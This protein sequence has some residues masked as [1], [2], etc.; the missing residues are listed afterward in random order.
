MIPSTPY[1]AKGLL[2]AAIRDPD[3][4]LFFE[5]KKLYRSLKEELPEGEHLVPLG[6]AR[7]AR[8]GDALTIFSYGYYLQVGRWATLGATIIAIGTALIASGYTNLMDYLQT[9]FG[10]FNAPLFAT[11]ILGMFWKRMTPAAGLW[12]LVA[13]TIAAMVT[14]VG[15][16]WAGWFTFGS[17]LDE[18]FWGAGAAFIVDIVVTVVVS[19]VTARPEPERLAGIVY[20]VPGADGVA[21]TLRQ[22]RE[23]GS[24]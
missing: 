2:I 9:L 17:D 5:H 1:E 19:L 6:R 18:S 8:A 16:K 12:G 24:Q 13:G 21:P 7:V 14:Y 23:R 22:P 10:L 3:P 20:G 15:Y 4:V 11:F